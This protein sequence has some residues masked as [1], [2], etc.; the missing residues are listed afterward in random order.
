MK[1]IKNKFSRRDFMKTS[2]AIAGAGVAAMSLG[3]RVFAQE[4]ATVRAAWVGIG[5]GTAV[6]SVSAVTFVVARH[7]LPRLYTLDTEVI[8]AAAALLPIAAAFQLADGA[9]VVGGGVLRGM[10]RTRPAAWFNLIAYYVLALPAAW[11]LA[12][13]AGQGLSGIWWGLTLG[14]GS[15][16]VLLLLWIGRFGPAH[17]ASVLDDLKS[18]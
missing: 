16:A 13:R 5:L 4:R 17:A 14:I 9:Q 3:G 18:N 7:G 8:A 12:F 10:G 11:W 15:V 6:M 1:R 2:A